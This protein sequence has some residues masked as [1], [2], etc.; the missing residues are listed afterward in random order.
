MLTIDPEMRP[1]S[2]LAL[3]VT[4]SA[5]VALAAAPAAR[6]QNPAVT[7]SVD[8][9]RDRRPISPEIYGVAFATTAQLADLNVPLNHWVG[10]HTSRYNWQLN[11]DNGA[12]DRYFERIG[13]TSGAPGAEFDAFVQAT[14]D[15]GARADRAIGRTRRWSRGWHR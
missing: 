3:I 15:G 8:T 12:A 6:A 13:Y 10:N 9:A 7:I 14:R 4:L 5:L 2:R 1:A 11:A